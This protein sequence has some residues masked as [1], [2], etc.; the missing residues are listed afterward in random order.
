[1]AENF[2]D[3]E[4]FNVFMMKVKSYMGSIIFIGKEKG[5]VESS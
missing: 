2:T 4:M 1:M 3:D 5:I